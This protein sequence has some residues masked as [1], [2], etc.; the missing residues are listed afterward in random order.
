MFSFVYFKKITCFRRL[1]SARGSLYFSN[2]L[3]KASFWTVLFF[4]LRW[5]KVLIFPFLFVIFYDQLHN[6][7]SSFP[8]PD[9]LSASTATHCSKDAVP[10]SWTKAGV[11]CPYPS[12]CQHLSSAAV[13]W[14]ESNLHNPFRQNKSPVQLAS[15]SEKRCWCGDRTRRYGMNEKKKQSSKSQT[16]IVWAATGQHKVH[17]FGRRE[18]NEGEFLVVASPSAS[19][20]AAFMHHCIQLGNNGEPFL[21]PKLENWL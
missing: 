14:V 8:L 7:I 12:V 19:L 21:C 3:W 4:I 18:W 20:P 1:N 6:K 16:S 9:C 5:M 13:H 11:L 10:L 2:T 17:P 15:Q